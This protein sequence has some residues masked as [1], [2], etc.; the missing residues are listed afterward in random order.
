MQRGVVAAVLVL[1]L[2]GCGFLVRSDSV[3]SSD[4][5]SADLIECRELG[6]GKIFV[7]YENDGGGSTT[8]VNKVP[9]PGENAASGA[10]SGEVIGGSPRKQRQKARRA[11]KALRANGWTEK[12]INDV[13]TLPDDNEMAR[14]FGW[15][16]QTDAEID[17][18]R[19]QLRAML[20]RMPS[21]L[22]QAR[23]D[24]PTE[25]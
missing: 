6:P 5:T 19:R 24:Q 23:G 21:C 14:N 13:I 17:G 22:E 16:G 2:S 15:E 25:G 7:E 12:D 9:E 3:G 18:R 10:L 11:E 20:D 4:F 8:V 1:T